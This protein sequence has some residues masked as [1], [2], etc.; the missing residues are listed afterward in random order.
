MSTDQ[1]ITIPVTLDK[2]TFR[3]FATFDTFRRQR[4][5]RLPFAFFVILAAFSVFLYLQ[6]DKPQAA[7]IATVL[8]S[9]GVL[10]PLV[11]V[12]TFYMNLRTSTESHRLPRLVYTLTLSGEDVSILSHTQSGQTLTLH[13]NQLFA[14]YR[15]RGAIY[16][17]VLPTRAFLLPD[18]QADVSADALWDY[19]QTRLQD[20][21]RSFC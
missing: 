5:W 19:I 17:Y 20:K 4:R 6:T 3:R 18:G 8:L 14:A 9:V 16:L 7:L 11:Y 15:V 1:A 12:L 10:L 13:W 21:C 2:R